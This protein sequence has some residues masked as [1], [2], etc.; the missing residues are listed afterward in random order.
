[1]QALRTLFFPVCFSLVVSIGSCWCKPVAGA[2]AK[3]E[4]E[5]LFQSAEGDVSVEEDQ[6]AQRRQRSALEGIKEEFLRKLN[7]SEVPRERSKIDPPQFMIELYNRYATDKSFMPRSDV[8]RSF[9]LQDVTHSETNDDMSKY[10]LLFNISIPVQEQVTMAEL[11][12][13]TL[14][15]KRTKISGE[16]LATIKIYAVERGV[17]GPALRFL[18]GE[19]AVGIRPW[20]AF[21]ITDAV[22]GWLRSGRGAN[23]LEVHVEQRGC[24]ALRGSGLDVS[25]SL[26]GNSSAA[27]IVFSD[28]LGNRQKEA[29][30]E[31]RDMMA[32]EDESMF[33]GT[34]VPADHDDN[35]VPADIQA[36]L[37]VDV[38]LRR[39]RQARSDYCRRTS[40]HVNFK[41]IGW[42]KW[43]VAPEEYDAFECRGVCYFPLTDD[44]SP[45]KH[46]VIQALVNLSN[47]KKANMACCV[48]TKLDPITIL[49]KENG[50]I[51]VQH[52]YKEM[53]VAECGC[54]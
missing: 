20:E 30:K 13:F 28:D 4:A 15:D 36:G 31:L 40:L 34:D 7:L 3:E 48:P 46:A 24:R 22:H 51:T 12:L 18:S 27:L 32:H 38:R 1:M 35:D 21:D 8:I 44:L 9:L 10:R 42:D 37:P 52:L 16:V 53:K 25:L 49:Y 5:S 23:E 45:T 11:R 6:D 50:I 2:V 19:D 33:S 43:I 26:K 47:P 17:V 14:L 41:D 29:N 39:R 54:R